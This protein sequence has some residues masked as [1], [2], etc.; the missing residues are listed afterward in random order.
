M[1][2]KGLGKL[3]GFGVAKKI[4][5]ITKT[6][7]SAFAIKITLDYDELVKQATTNEIEISEEVLE[8]GGGIS[9]VQGTKIILS[10]T[11]MQKMV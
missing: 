5:L 11:L 8:D 2:R 10:N 9:G 6:S 1:G 7:A 4:E 3:A